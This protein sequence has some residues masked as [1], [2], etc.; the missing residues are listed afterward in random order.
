MG[1]YPSWRFPAQVRLPRCLHSWLSSLILCGSVAIFEIVTL[2]VCGAGLSSSWLSS[3]CC[4]DALS[5][6]QMTF[7]FVRMAGV[8]GNCQMMIPFV[9]MCVP[10]VQLVS[11][12]CARSESRKDIWLLVPS[13]QLISF[14]C[15]RFQLRISCVSFAI[16]FLHRP[17]GV[18]LW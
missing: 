7:L 2:I 17:H 18:V 14:L 11:F 15:A 16:V 3:S 6:C 12:L 10:S 4:A 8:L 13:A 1:T 5:I 9:T